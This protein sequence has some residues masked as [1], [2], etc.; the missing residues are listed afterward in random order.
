MIEAYRTLAAEA[1]RRR[2]ALLVEARSVAAL[3]G[4]QEWAVF[5]GVL[6]R[7]I[8][9]LRAGLEQGALE[10]LPALQQQIQTLRWVLDLPTT[11]AAHVEADARMAEAQR[12]SEPE[13]AELEARDSEPESAVAAEEIP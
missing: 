8:E 9:A 4:T 6:Q 5:A 11:L 13:P 3:A 2:A 1:E 12:P 7:R 10:T